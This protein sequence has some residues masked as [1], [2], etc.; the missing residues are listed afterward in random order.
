MDQDAMEKMFQPNADSV[1]VGASVEQME[2]QCELIA[3]ERIL[4]RYYSKHTSTSRTSVQEFSPTLNSS[5]LEFSQ[6][7][8]FPERPRANRNFA[9]FSLRAGTSAHH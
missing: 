1:P 5:K 7:P 9:P 6:F 8:M 3:M 2:T 4:Q